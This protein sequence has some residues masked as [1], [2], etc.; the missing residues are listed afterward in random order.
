MKKTIA[1]LALAT[2]LATAVATANPQP[3]GGKDNTG[4]LYRHEASNPYTDRVA[5]RKGDLLLIVINERS[6][7]S[8]A[9]ATQAS[10]SDNNRVTADVFKGLLGRLFGPLTNS[11]SS[12]VSG[13]GDTNQSG[14]MTA[15]MSA[16]VS[17]A[18]PNGTLVIQGS[19]TLV[20]N[21]ETQTF[22]LSGLI[23]AGD[24][25][26]DN[27]IDSTKIAEAEIRMEGKGLVSERQR[28]GVLTQL[29]DW[30]F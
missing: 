25:A 10:K 3:D 24:I 19:R 5:R 16:V 17:E 18:R 13:E 6:A 4:S 30:L 27:T 9:A 11:G 12:G 1:Y 29:L 22:V 20:T 23:R 14:N 8:F 21:R 26:P 15:R 28:K 2:F 7:A